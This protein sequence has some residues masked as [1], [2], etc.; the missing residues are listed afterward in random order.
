MMST[1]NDSWYFSDVLYG[2]KAPCGVFCFTTTL[3]GNVAKLDRKS[4]VTEPMS[5]SLIDIDCQASVLLTSPIHVFG[6]WREIK[7]T[8][9]AKMRG[10]LSS[11][12]EY[13]WVWAH[14]GCVSEVPRL[15]ELQSVWFNKNKLP[16]EL[17]M[18]C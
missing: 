15:I 18:Y 14:L 9:F 4:F 10:E 3:S 17:Q 6:G 16:N 1:D 7:V 11:K 8:A 12:S 5:A 2:N 13:K